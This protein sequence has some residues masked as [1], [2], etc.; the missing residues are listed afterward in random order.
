MRRCHMGTNGSVRDQPLRPLSPPSP[1]IGPLSLRADPKAAGEASSSLHGP[2]GPLPADQESP[3]QP[4]S[5][6]LLLGLPSEDESFPHP[7]CSM[8]QGQVH[9]ARGRGGER[10]PVGQDGS[11]RVRPPGLSIARERCVCNELCLY[12]EVC[13]C[14]GVCILMR[15]V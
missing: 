13:A 11:H 2:G 10:E 3:D 8:G 7:S 1:A 5:P 9:S 4:R 15:H 6:V 14:N 12:N